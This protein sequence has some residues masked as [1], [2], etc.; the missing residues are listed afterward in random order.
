M[1]KIFTTL[2]IT[3]AISA[4]AVKARNIISSKMSTQK[5]AEAQKLAKECQAR[6]YKNCE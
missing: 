6:N 5:I 2:I 1:L 3:L 4:S